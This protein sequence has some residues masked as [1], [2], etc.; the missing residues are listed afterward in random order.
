[1]DLYQDGFPHHFPKLSKTKEMLIAH[2]YHVKKTYL[3]K[4]GMVG[5][6]GDVLNIEQDIS[7][8]VSFYLKE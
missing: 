5:Y 6:K 3:L 1:M 4:G 8:L 7:G 2:L